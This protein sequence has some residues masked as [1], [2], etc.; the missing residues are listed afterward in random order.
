MDPN[1]FPHL[2]Q[3]KQVEELSRERIRA[4]LGT[5]H[6]E[7]A[8]MRQIARIYAENSEITVIEATTIYLA[9]AM[10]GE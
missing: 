10:K 2:S 3:A 9:R 6:D 5:D 7:D 8:A 4:T 1:L